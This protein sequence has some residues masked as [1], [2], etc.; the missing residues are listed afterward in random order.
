VCQLNIDIRH[1]RVNNNKVA[2]WPFALKTWYLYDQLS[3]EG[4]HLYLNAIMY[5]IMS[6][7]FTYGCINCISRI[8]AGNIWSDNVCTAAHL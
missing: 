5:V 2:V 7:V 8:R 1:K 4:K 3:H 6:T